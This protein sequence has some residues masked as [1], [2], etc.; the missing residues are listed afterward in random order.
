M[1]PLTKHTATMQMLA[2]RISVDC[3]DEYLRIGESTAIE[4]MKNFVVEIIQVFR[5]EHLRR[6]T[7]ADV[8]HLLQVVKAHNFF[9]MLESIDC[10][11]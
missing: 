5:E 8:Y 7:E 10:M 6:L 3:F 2:Y 4:C 11:Y 1:L 9:G